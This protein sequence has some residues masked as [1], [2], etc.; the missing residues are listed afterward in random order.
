[1]NDERRERR[2]ERGE[3]NTRWGDIHPFFFAPSLFR[4]PFCL[5]V[6]QEKR[7]IS[8]LPVAVRCR[9][10]ATSVFL[11][12]LMELLRE[13]WSFLFGVPPGFPGLTL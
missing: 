1:M 7:Q 9:V 8:S 13:A 12:P 10:C 4:L 6:K 3:R 2:D 5:A 11:H